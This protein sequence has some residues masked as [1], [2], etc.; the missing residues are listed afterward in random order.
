MKLAIAL[1]SLVLS[2]HLLADDAER[3]FPLTEATIADGR[4]VVAEENGRVVYTFDVDDVN[5]SNCYDGCAKTWPPR[6]VTDTANIKAPMGVTKR[7]DGT[8][9]LTLESKPLYYF[10]GD[11]NPG[12]INGDGLG[13]VWH[14]I[15][16]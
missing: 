2:T 5:V 16:D 1:F 7:K 4:E 9:Q 14:I 3:F 10:K 6:L 12:D 11:K 8:L 13:G 15:E